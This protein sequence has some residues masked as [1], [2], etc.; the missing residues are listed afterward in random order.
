MK[1]DEWY[2]SDKFKTLRLLNNLCADMGQLSQRIQD[3]MG[4]VDHQF[5]LH[6]IV[7]T[8]SDK[9]H[10]LDRQMRIVRLEADN[11]RNLSEEM[12]RKLTPT[13]F[14]EEGGNEKQ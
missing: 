8:L 11:L 10:L 14:D 1:R 7:G 3:V 4:V 12:T 6:E 2:E 9:R 5:E 13:K